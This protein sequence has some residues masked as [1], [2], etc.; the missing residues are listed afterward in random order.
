M[1]ISWDGSKKDKKPVA[2]IDRQGDLRII[3]QTGVRVLVISAEGEQIWQG[4]RWEP[5]DQSVQHRFY[6]GDQI[7][8]TF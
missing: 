3:N 5:D 8:I 4:V 2:Y 1:K 6:S 7:T